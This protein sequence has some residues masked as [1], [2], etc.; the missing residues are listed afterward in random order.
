[1]RNLVRACIGLAALGAT[2]AASAQTKP[3][4]T[5]GRTDLSSSVPAQKMAVDPVCR[6]VVDLSTG[7]YTKFDTNNNNTRVLVPVFNSVDS[8]IPNAPG[9]LNYAWTPGGG[10]FNCEFNDPNAPAISLF[11]HPMSQDGCTSTAA[12]G[13]TQGWSNNLDILVDNY[14]VDL[15]NWNGGDPNATDTIDQIDVRIGYTGATGAPV[16]IGL[17][18]GYYEWLDRNGD[19]FF[20]R[21][22]SGPWLYLWTLGGSGQGTLANNTAGLGLQPYGWDMMLVDFVDSTY[23]PNTGIATGTPACGLYL[24]I[25]GGV[26]QIGNV[27]FGHLV[28]DPN[29]PGCRYHDLNMSLG[30]FTFPDLGSDIWVMQ[31]GFADPNGTLIDPNSNGV[32]GLQYEEIWH[33]GTGVWLTWVLGDSTN[34]TRMPNSGLYRMFVT[35]PNEPNVPPCGGA[36]LNGDNVVD[37]TD[38]AILLSDFDCTSACVGDVDGDDDTDLTDLAVLLANFDCTY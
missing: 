16:T 9:G 2:V 13:A 11:I 7:E 26:R 22:S 25:A 33:F 35:E 4:I 1:M 15:T 38:L 37:L 20:Y 19:G 14:F 28:G 3:N 31:N 30:K 8:T 23:D 27:N 18:L 5:S 6:G 17:V 36:D 29:G 21:V 10:R 24:P 32:P 12:W 34:W